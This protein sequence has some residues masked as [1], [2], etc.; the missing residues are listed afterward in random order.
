[1]A[2]PFLA[3]KIINPYLQ[4]RRNPYLNR[5]NVLTPSQ[6]E[7]LPYVQQEKAQQEREI[8]WLQPLELI[9]DLLSRGQYL[10]ANIGEDVGRAISGENVDILRGAWEGITG[11]RKGSWKKTFFGGTD[12]GEEDRDAYEGWFK[13]TPDWMRA[14]AKIPIIGPTSL[15]DVIGFLGDVFLDPTTYISFGS[16]KA[17]EA[18]AQKYAEKAVVQTVKQLGSLETIKKFASK[19]F[20]SDVFVKLL[21]K[22]KAGSKKALTEA[23]EYL[24][25]HAA[26]KDIARFLNQVT[27]K[28]YK[29]GLS[30]TPD[31]V[32]KTFSKNL[33]ADQA[34]YIDDTAK[35]LAKSGKRQAKEAIKALKGTGE[36]SLSHL[37]EL[38]NVVKKAGPEDLKKVYKELLKTG[39]GGGLKA[40]TDMPETIAKKFSNLGQYSKE[41]AQTQSPEFLQE[42]AGMGERTMKFFG[43][44][45]FKGVRQKNIVSRSFD[46]FMEAMKKTKVGGSFSN[47]IW[48][49]M[50]T[51]P[52][53]QLRRMFGFK[54]PYQKMLRTKELEVIQAGEVNSQLLLDNI[55]N[56][57]DGFDDDIMK[58]S[59]DVLTLAEDI[60]PEDIG[61]ILNKPAILEKYGIDE[62]N[63][64]KIKEFIGGYK[65]Y[66][67]DFF[68]KEMSL[69]KE[70]LYP[71]D[72]GY[73]NYYLPKVTQNKALP[74]GKMTVRGSFAPGHTQTRALSMSE[75]I[76]GEVEKLKLLLSVDDETAQYMVKQLNWSTT[77][78]DIREMLMHRAIAHNQVMTHADLIRKFKEYGVSF[79]GSHIGAAISGTDFFGDFNPTDVNRNLDLFSFLKTKGMEIP[80]LGLRQVNHPALQ[81]KYFDKDVADIIDRVVSVTGSDEGLNWFLQKAGAFTA[82]WK[83]MAT[84]SPGFHF[85]N[86]FS[87]RFTLFMKEGMSSFNPK[88]NI[89]SLIGTTYGLYGENFVKK[90]K[91]GDDFIKKRLHMSGT[92][93]KTYAEWAEIARKHGLI[94]KATYAFDPKDMVKQ[95]TEPKGISKKLNLFSNE[96]IL[97]EK[98]RELGAIVESTSKFESFIIEL[99]KMAKS[100][101]DGIATDAMIEKAVV[102]TKKFFF[103]YTD[104]TEFEQKVMKNIIPFYTWLRKNVAL[105][106]T[107]MIENKQMYSVV[108]KAMRGIQAE[109]TDIKDLPEYM[110]EAGYIPTEVTEGGKVKTWWSNMPY[111]DINKLPFRFEVNDAGIPIPKWTPQEMTEEFLSS[112]N[113]VL[114][115]FAEVMGSEKGYDFFRKK[116][117]DSQSVAPRVMRLFA[118]NPQMLGF[119]DSLIKAVGYKDGLEARRDQQGRL[120][121]DAKIQKILENN[122]ILLERLDQSWDTITTVIP[123][124][125]DAAAKFTGYE[126]KYQGVDKFLRVISFMFGIKEREL[127]LEEERL[128]RYKKILEDAE[129]ERR[130]ERKKQ[131]GYEKRTNEYLLKERRRMRKLG[132]Y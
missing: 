18:A 20:D 75:S 82:W 102:D 81:G 72:V 93:G 92:A 125:E 42:F 24:S 57:V 73:L 74:K 111:A 58:K 32:Q 76:A 27:K 39:K 96:N 56:F 4:S 61:M 110:R 14:E 55:R 70:G 65:K 80:E 84:L 43:G 107:Q 25:K 6:R 9:F 113:P 88:R 115:T 68:Q 99:E 45:F 22:G 2:N 63:I 127:D 116:D 5:D 33:L 59:T 128:Y 38:M 91:F 35:A 121:I 83:G 52:V 64:D 105:Q 77:N 114:K 122:F 37:D 13:D 49:I 60:N 100:S 28:A 90:F 131:P 11:K 19:A 130:K 26:K 124:L 50:N 53:G 17:A 66:T 3:N 16:S 117:L 21:N 1:M 97:F 31:V 47:A 129:A 132:L 87:N 120:V 69:A 104:L 67:D 12:K 95:F 7:L 29:E 78:M 51:G 112:A 85:R 108:A 54:N 10:T 44:E 106:A 23:T 126:N 123:Q 41:L 119:M 103:D 8:N 109:G 34:R 40:I 62:K 30:L 48:N 86:H 79:G 36:I 15:Q 98:S 94:T 71:E 89:D 118:A 101:T 46:S